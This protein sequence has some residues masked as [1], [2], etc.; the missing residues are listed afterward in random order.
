MRQKQYNSK[1]TKVDQKEVLRLHSNHYTIKD[2]CTQLETTEHVVIKILKLN[3]LKGGTKIDRL[4]DKYDDI[5]KSYRQT[6]KLTLVAKEFNTTEN[7]VE[8]ILNLY[9]VPKRHEQKKDLDINEVINFYKEVHKVKLVADKFNLSNSVILKILHS[10]NVR[11]S[12]I[13]YTDQEIIEKYLELKTIISTCNI[14]G[15][16]EKYLSNVLKK[17]NV[18]LLTL[19]RKEIGEV[20][21]KLTIIGEEESIV[22]PSGHKTK[23]FILRCEC[24]T[25]VTRR[26]NKLS[27]DKSSHC[28]C[29]TKELKDKKEEGR[30]MREEKRQKLL[31]ERE[32]K[33]KNRPVKKSRNKYFV[34]S[35]KGR[36]TILS[37]SDDKW[38]ARTILCKCE[39]GTI[40]EMRYQNIYGV[41][42]CGC[43]SE[44]RVKA[45]TTHG[46]APKNNKYQRN[47]YDRWRGMVKR[48]H[49]PKSHAYPDYGGRGIQVCDRWREPNGVGCKNYIDDIHNTLGPQP[50]P[51]YSLDRINND[52]NYDIS[53]LR[54]ATQ[55]VQSQNQRRRKKSGN[56]D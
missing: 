54:W 48:C 3:G 43:L 40:K 34:G 10:N 16:S 18:K 29:V 17:H 37:I 14:L 6:N 46:L 25:I 9:G 56:S 55:S 27:N 2:I 12:K 8:K 33:R 52:G 1:S 21:G 41:N 51:G 47:W 39:C 50:G 15:I 53:N 49:N 45:S 22:S 28:G 32:E 11:V 24:G 19:K 35:I 26:S 36:L 23:K 13:K 38:E 5:I 31:L 30:K 4:K 42:S 20:F 7:L 44:N